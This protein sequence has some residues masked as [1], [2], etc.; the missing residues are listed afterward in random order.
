[1][2]AETPTQKL[3]RLSSP[4]SVLVLPSVPQA[5]QIKVG[6]P[7]VQIALP[8]PGLDGA[9]GYTSVQ[10]DLYK[11]S[12]K[13]RATVKLAM[14]KMQAGETGNTTESYS[15][16]GEPYVPL[17]IETVGQT[18]RL[19]LAGVVVLTFV[20]DPVAGQITTSAH[21]PGTKGWTHGN[22]TGPDVN[23]D[24]TDEDE[25]DEDED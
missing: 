21:Q 11:L 18:A 15:G 1:M 22:E 6:R 20:V 16:S 14:L 19:L 25:E 8:V 7:H 13:D 10:A 5:A 9:M 2:S 12:E 3:V 23:A 4:A 24:E 17:V